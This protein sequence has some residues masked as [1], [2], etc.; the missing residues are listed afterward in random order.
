M[1]PLRLPGLS[2]KDIG[3][4]TLLYSEENEAIHVLNGTARAIWDL[5]DGQHTFIDIEQALRECF[6]VKTEHNVH[7]DI[8]RTVA[9]FQAKG[10]LQPTDETGVC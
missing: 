8:Q 7:G 6:S 3:G 9:I 5:C 10:L 4:E 2:M 1:K